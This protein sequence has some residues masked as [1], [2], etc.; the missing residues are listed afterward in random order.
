MGDAVLKTIAKRLNNY[1][2]SNGYSARLG[3]DEFIF[4]LKVSKEHA[5]IKVDEIKNLIA[6]PIEY[7]DKTLKVGTSVGISNYP[8]DSDN[9]SELIKL[10]DEQMYTE[11]E[12]R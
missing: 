12:E 1:C 10:A 8:E 7:K 6:K 3:G 2:S 9:V 5:I 11:K 4:M